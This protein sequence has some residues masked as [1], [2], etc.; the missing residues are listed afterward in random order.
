MKGH[1]PSKNT[2]YSLLDDR[3]SIPRRDFTTEQLPRPPPS[4][5]EP[6]VETFADMS[7]PQPYLCRRNVGRSSQHWWQ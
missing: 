6:A 7:K 4:I 2:T 1:S 3:I 5:K